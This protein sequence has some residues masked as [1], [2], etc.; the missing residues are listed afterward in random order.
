METVGSEKHDI[1]GVTWERPL[2]NQNGSLYVTI[3]KIWCVL[4]GIKKGDK[5]TLKL[6]SDGSLKVTAPREVSS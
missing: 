6:L 3:P 4:H 1:N 2:V 5:I